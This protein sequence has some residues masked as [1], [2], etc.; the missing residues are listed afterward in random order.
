MS[1]MLIFRQSTYSELSGEG[2]KF[3]QNDRPWKSDSRVAKI[4][5][6]CIQDTVFYSLYITATEDA[7]VFDHANYSRLEF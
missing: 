3:T 7:S 5:K 2:A 6:H 4:L 1:S